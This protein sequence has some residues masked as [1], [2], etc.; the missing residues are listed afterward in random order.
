VRINRVYNGKLIIALW[1]AQMYIEN[2]QMLHVY[3]VIKLVL[4]KIVKKEIK[5]NDV[6]KRF[7]KKIFSIYK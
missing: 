7:K 4:M 1:L 5:K 2:L 6:K 3:H